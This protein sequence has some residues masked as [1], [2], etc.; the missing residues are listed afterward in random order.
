MLPNFPYFDP[1]KLYS[2]KNLSLTGNE[3]VSTYLSYT[4]EES[5]SGYYLQHLYDGAYDHDYK[6]YEP[7]NKWR[8]SV[9]WQIKSVPDEE[10]PYFT[11]RNQ[12]LDYG[13][14]SITNYES[15][16]GYYVEHLY[17]KAYD[18]EKKFYEA[19]Q[20][21]RD[22]ILWEINEVKDGIFTIA[23]KE[24]NY[25]NIGYTKETAIA[26]AYLS[27]TEKRAKSGPYIQVLCGENY[28]ESKSYYQK[29]GKWENS[30]LWEIK[31]AK[32]C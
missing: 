5:R 13:Y 12:M 26:D 28:Q 14:M 10:G 21:F 31:E 3:L 19:G 17:C 20:K 16:S 4:F 22:K 27:Y 2:I 9:L 29:G 18:K 8:N 11:F 1:N 30:I 23:N 15:A 24:K 25:Y 6:Y 32:K 7:D